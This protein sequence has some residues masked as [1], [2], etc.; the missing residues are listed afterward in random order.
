MS[1][2]HTNLHHLEGRACYFPIL[3]TRAW[4]TQ[5]A[6][7]LERCKGRNSNPSDPYPGCM[8]STS[9]LQ[10]IF[11]GN[12]P[13]SWKGS[14]II[15]LMRRIRTKETVT[16]QGASA[17]KWKTTQSQHSA[18]RPHEAP[19]CT[20]KTC[21]SHLGPT[22]RTKSQEFC[23]QKMGT[24]LP[25]LTSLKIFFSYIYFKCHIIRTNW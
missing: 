25:C 14:S 8:L 6:V 22:Q 11:Q 15:S 21:Q 13:N 18:L 7:E 2:A 16:Q 20:L 5:K 12:S 19:F 3:W 23:Y 10:G 24:S 9:V 1:L 4:G 17:D